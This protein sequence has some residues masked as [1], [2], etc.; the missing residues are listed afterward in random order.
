MNWVQRRS[1]VKPK[2]WITILTRTLISMMNSPL[3]LSLRTRTIASMSDK[4]N[5][6][7]KRVVAKSFTVSHVA[8]YST[9][10]LL[11][12][13]ENH[14]RKCR[15][16]SLIFSLNHNYLLIVEQVCTQR[17]RSTKLKKENDRIK[18][19]ISKE[20]EYAEQHFAFCIILSVRRCLRFQNHLML[21]ASD[22]ECMEGSEK[23]RHIV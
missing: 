8:Q 14:V 18:N 20:S 13:T 16:R 21:M 1:N 11:L 2:L 9:L 12:T 22:H 5:S 7:M 6:G 17:L 10:T 19:F 15:G 4:Q 23:H 3:I